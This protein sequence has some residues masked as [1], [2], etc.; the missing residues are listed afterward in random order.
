[1]NVREG[2]IRFGQH[3]LEVVSGAGRDLPFAAHHEFPG[4]GRPERDRGANVVRRECRE[5]AENP[6]DG[7]ALR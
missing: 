1:M 7:G 4:R 3:V 6:F 5:V 2:G